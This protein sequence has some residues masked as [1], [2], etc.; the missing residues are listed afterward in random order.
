M[1]DNALLI[2]NPPQHTAQMDPAALAEAFRLFNEASG[3]L[4]RAYDGLQA[5]VAQLTVELA[6]ANGELRRQYQEKAALTERLGTLLAALPAGVVVLDGQG[7]VDEANPAAMA[8]LG[9]DIVGWQWEELLAN[10]AEPRDAANEWS[11]AATLRSRNA[12][13]RARFFR[14]TNRAAAGCDR[15]PAHAHAGRTQRAL[16]G[17]G[18]NGRR[19]GP[20]AEDTAGGSAALCG[21]LRLAG[22]ARAG[23]R[24]RRVARRRAPATSRGADPRHAGIRPR[25][26]RQPRTDDDRQTGR[27]GNRQLRPDRPRQG[28]RV[29][30]AGRIRQCRGV[31]QPQRPGR[32]A[33]QPDRQRDR[34][35]A[36]RRHRRAGC[37]G[38]CDKCHVLRLRQRSRHRAVTP[39]TIV[40]AVLHDTG[41]RHRARAR[42]RTRR[43]TRPWRRPRT[44]SRSRHAGPDDGQRNF[45]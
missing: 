9:S 38:R 2:D 45:G 36:G 30:R 33:D 26:D 31:G 32:R 20:P 18:R 1:T 39:E 11:N 12:R 37:R 29:S 25:R 14:R 3:E 27:R 22:P 41:A 8:M 17:D 43:G 40:R 42:H 15:S 23:P 35:G 44:A 4:S 19:A 34:R 10:A 7:T 5:Q 16:G 6:Q 24:T 28:R 13:D 21:Q